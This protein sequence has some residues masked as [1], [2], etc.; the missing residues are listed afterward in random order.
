MAVR[1]LVHAWVLVSVVTLAALGACGCG[2]GPAASPSGSGHTT[3]GGDTADPAP[4]D[5]D[6][7]GVADAL[8]ACLDAPEDRD[9]FDDEDGCPDPDNDG[10]GVADIDD[11]CPNDASYRSRSRQ[12]AGEDGALGCPDGSEREYTDGPP[13]D[14]DD[15]GYP[16][17]V[18]QC[19]RHAETFPS[20]LD[21][22]CTD[23]GDGCPDGGSILL[24]ACE[25]AILD[26]V[27]FAPNGS[28]LSPDGALVADALAQ[29]LQA[30]PGVGVDV[31]G[32]TDD[33]ERESVAQQRAQAVH[34]ALVARGVPASQLGVRAVGASQPVAAIAGVRGRE[35]AAARERNRRVSFEVTR[36]PRLPGR[37]TER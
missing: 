34:D 32:H 4:T 30:N 14:L 29:T 12:G 11:M 3:G 20:S 16:D 27:Y 21:G 5:A 25:V 7:D 1:R 24:V 13:G 35:L 22:G 36:Q 15:D 31:V 18:D 9:G 28:A 6:E 26:V 17:E 10:D 33:R 19:P 23:D 8:D 2:A 37:P